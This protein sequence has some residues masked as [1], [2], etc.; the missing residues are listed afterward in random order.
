MPKRLLMLVPGAALLVACSSPT[1]PDSSLTAGYMLTIVPGSECPA[2]PE[3]PTA[4]WK[5]P[6]TVVSENRTIQATSAEQTQFAPTVFL[7]LYEG[8]AP[9]T[10]ELG[11]GYR[12][13]TAG[14]LLTVGSWP[15]MIGGIYGPT[16]GRV[17]VRAEGSLGTSIRG[18]WNG[19]VSVQLPGGRWISC[20]WPT[21]QFVLERSS[22]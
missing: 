2:W 17:P 9:M 20:G 14:W 21:H 1:G 8:G 5:I 16:D 12:P 11:G 22:R 7:R 10:G 15:E 3:T 18:T 4:L 6:V 19:F 13:G